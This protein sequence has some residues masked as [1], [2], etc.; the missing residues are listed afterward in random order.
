MV[1]AWLVACFRH[2]EK[3]PDRLA[4]A[5]G[6]A[7][8]AMNVDRT[9]PLAR[10]G[11]AIA[12][13]VDRG[14]GAGIVGGYHAPQH[15]VEVVLSALYLAGREKLAGDA[16]LEILTAAVTHDF[17]YD[18]IRDPKR[19]SRLEVRAARK[20]MSYLRAAGVDG[21]AQRRLQTLVL[22]TEPTAGVPFARACHAFHHVD[23][24]RPTS[25]APLP[26]LAPLLD[27]PALALAAALLVEA[28]VLP[29]IGLTIEHGNRVQALLSVEWQRPL[30]ARDKL[31]YIDDIFG[32]FVVARF[33][34]PNLKALREDCLRRL[35]AGH[36]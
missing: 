2:L 33:F 18:G 27:D 10:A 16:A 9:L 21:T 28:D 14:I 6:A 22:S 25:A 30:G 32:D 15:F 23:G 20:A 29:S 3:R 36:G 8:D 19:P 12:A 34:S 17:H 13:D 1:A 24:P 5:Y 35:Q 7:L 31:H 4:W 26:E 11:L